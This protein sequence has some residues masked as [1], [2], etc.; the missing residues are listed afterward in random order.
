MRAALLAA[1]ILWTTLCL[2][3]WLP[4]TRT[5]TAVLTAALV[6]VH[7]LDP[8]R[9]SRA[10]AAG[11]VF[12]PFVA[13]AAANVVWVT[14]VPWMGWSDWIGWA[15]MLAI[16]WVVLN[17]LESRGAAGLLIASVGLAGAISASMA[18]Y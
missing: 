10:H 11:W 6:V 17:G 9:G 2:G 3:G 1:N 7:L 18:L 14:P 13:Y 12:V 8:V 16:F 5:V 4:E 15:Q